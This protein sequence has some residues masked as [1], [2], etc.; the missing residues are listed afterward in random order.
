MIDVL[1]RWR[2]RWW[3][4]WGMD[5]AIL[6]LIFWGVSLYNA[7][8]L[9]ETGEQLE[10]VQLQT[11]DGGSEPLWE[12]GRTTLVYVWAPWCGVCSAETGAV[13][14]ARGWVGDSVSVKSVVFDWRSP[15]QV[16]DYMADN[17]VDYPVLLG[18]RALYNSL[19]IRSFPTFYWI[20]PEG[21]V[22]GTAV[23]YT[24]SVGLVL[25]SW[26]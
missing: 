4:R 19:N 15:K 17:Q 23:G 13:S 22:E 11:P 20:S 12:E 26:L 5:L 1:K 10:S 16:R 2:Q 7:R 14:R 24:T 3:V 18:T 8:H 6:A 9:K 25:R 21:R